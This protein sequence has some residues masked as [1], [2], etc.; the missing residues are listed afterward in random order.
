[1]TPRT[2]HRTLVALLSLLVMSVL[3]ACAGPI[4]LAGGAAGAG[5]VAAQE[6]SVGAAV[7]DT[8][9]QLQIRHHLFQASEDLFNRVGSEVHEGRVLLTGV[10]PTPEDRVEAVRLAWQANGVQEVLNEIQ[11]SDR[12]GIIDYFKDAKITAQLRFQMLRDRDVSDINF[13]VETVNGIVY[14]MGIARTGSELEKI[15][16]HAR[17]IAGVQKVISHVRL[18][19]GRPREKS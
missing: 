10:V 2:S 1:M 4:L 13:S 5:I 12:D 7:D 16:T 6:R 17:N 11:V 3:S 8:A 19:G 15:T 14:L 18:S 9:I